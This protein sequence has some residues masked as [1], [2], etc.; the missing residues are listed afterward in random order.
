[1]GCFRVPRVTVWQMRIYRR[2]LCSFNYQI[3]KLPNYQFQWV[4]MVPRVRHPLVNPGPPP[5]L[6]PGVLTHKSPITIH[7]CS[8]HFPLFSFN[9]ASFIRGTEPFRFSGTWASAYS[10]LSMAF[11]LSPN[12]V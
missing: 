12:A 4:P 1:M 11:A 6:T 5:P 8:S 7:Q 10:Q 3:T 9:S 2:P